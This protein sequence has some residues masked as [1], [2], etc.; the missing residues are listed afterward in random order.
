M[1]VVAQSTAGAWPPVSEGVDGLLLYGAE[2]PRFP[3]RDLASAESPFCD[4]RGV[5]VR[6][7][8]MFLLGICLTSP[9]WQ[10]GP[11]S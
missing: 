11:I 1:G 4:C 10:R 2:Y 5:V 9:S 8:V 6:I 7:G 3:W